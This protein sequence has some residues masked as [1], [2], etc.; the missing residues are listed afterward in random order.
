[1]IIGVGGVSEFLRRQTLLCLEP[2]SGHCLRME[3]MRGHHV[4]APVQTFT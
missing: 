4:A 1:M 2:P 3:H